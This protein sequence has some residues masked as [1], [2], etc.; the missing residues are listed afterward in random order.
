[1]FPLFQGIIGDQLNI[2][3]KN[4]IDGMEQKSRKILFYSYD[5]KRFFDFK[6]IL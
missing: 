3:G 1:M 2:A 5:F 4:F 6:C